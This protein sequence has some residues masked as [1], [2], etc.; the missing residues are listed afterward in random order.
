MHFGL[1]F[2]GDTRCDVPE[3]P[4]N[5]EDLIAF[6]ER[7]LDNLHITHGSIRSRVFLSVVNGRALVDHPQI[8]APILVGQFL[9]KQVVIGLSDDFRGFAIDQLTETLVDVEEGDTS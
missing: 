6:D 1:P 9:G 2:R 5:P 7:G 3:Y 4:L 8:I